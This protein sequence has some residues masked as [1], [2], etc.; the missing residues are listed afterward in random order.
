MK[1][2]RL[3]FEFFGRNKIP[4]I[5]IVITYTVVLFFANDSFGQYRYAAYTRDLMKRVETPDSLYCMPIVSDGDMMSSDSADP[6]GDFIDSIEEGA[7][8]CK[9]YTPFS[10][11]TYLAGMFNGTYINCDLF[12]PDMVERYALP[13]SGGNWSDMNRK[14]DDGCI[15]A[16][17]S[18]AFFMNMDVG[19]VAEVELNGKGSADERTLKFR[20][21]GKLAKPYAAPL[22]NAAGTEMSSRYLY[23]RLDGLI[24]M[25][26]D[27]LSDALDKCGGYISTTANFM[28]AYKSGSS[29]EEK[30]EYLKYFEDQFSV[31]T[32]DELMVKSNELISLELK[33]RLP[34]PIFLLTIT[35]VA[36]LSIS[37]LVINKKLREYS[38]YYLCGC[39][40]FKSYAIIS[41]AIT[42]M[43]LIGGLLNIV[44]M[45]GYYYL[46]SNGFIK[47]GGETI[48]DGF[49]VLFTVIFALVTA[50]L[51]IAISLLIFRKSSP[52]EIYRKYET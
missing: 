41:G 10:R 46:T 4:A 37:V 39:S 11:T 26:N 18:G 44:F 23:Q 21:V 27:E 38:I 32:Y 1:N 3:I 14:N 40:R 24:L 22:F 49:S 17:A 30:D 50:F 36:L 6:Y 5:I 8:K 52:I 47:G 20:I 34:I 13:L 16:I 9:A 48:Y 51:S 45:E 15:N 28:T 25:E 2:L 29:Q 31:F 35:C 33:R 12:T 43:S 7:K 42:L 19:D